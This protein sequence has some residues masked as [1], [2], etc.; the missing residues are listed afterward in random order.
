MISGRLI[1][2]AGAKTSSR[3]RSW[4]TDHLQTG[5]GNPGASKNLLLPGSQGRPA[6]KGLPKLSEIKL[7]EYD[8]I[9]LAKERNRLVDRW[10]KTCSA[11]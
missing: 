7:I 3:Q 9:A 5:A 6:G 1:I 8:R 11:K 4:S 2:V 10:V